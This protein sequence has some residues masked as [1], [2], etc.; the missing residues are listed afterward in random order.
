MSPVLQAEQRLDR[1]RKL[2]TL[3]DKEIREIEAEEAHRAKKA[4]QRDAGKP[5]GRRQKAE[6]RVTKQLERLGVTAH[7]VK[8]WAHQTG[9]VDQVRRG[10]IKA[11]LVDAYEAA[12]R[13]AGDA[14]A[15]PGR[16]ED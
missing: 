3:V 6:D 13:G 14:G 4:A 12:H 5:R 7:D 2:R 10:R 16:L 8:V 11:E 9:L 1:L 15:R